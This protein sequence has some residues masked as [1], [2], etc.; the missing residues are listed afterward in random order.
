MGIIRVASRP[1]FYAH[2]YDNNGVR[3]RLSLQTTNLRIARLK[4]A[5]I[6][7]ERGLN[8]LSGPGNDL[9]AST[10]LGLSGC[11]LVLFSTGRGT[12]F[13]SFIPTV[14]ISTNTDL[15]VNKPNWIDFNAGEM[16]A[17]NYEQITNDFI[18]Y[19][20]QV[21]EGKLTKNEIND[22]HEIAIFKTGVTLW[23]K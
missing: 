5:E 19:I 14:K 18:E 15:Y 8:V 4:Y 21:I 22:F 16:N 23:G 9:V 3:R 1:S 6:I 7:K 12:P 10:A 11:Q 17:S 20:I 13:G 2:F